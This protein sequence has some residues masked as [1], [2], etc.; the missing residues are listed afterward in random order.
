MRSTL[1]DIAAQ[2]GA[3]ARTLRRAAERGAVHCRRPGPRS[4]ELAPGELT[5][6][7]GHWKLLSVLTRALRTEPN[8]D[9][10]VLYGSAARGTEHARSDID[11]LV[12]FRDD[13]GA[14]TTALARRLEDRV[15]VPV[16]VASLS[17]V[18]R[19]SPLLLLQ[20][21]DEGRVLVDRGD[22][23][24]ALRRARETIARAARRQMDRARKQAAE[25]LASLLQEPR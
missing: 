24:E 5:Y 10:V 23:W 3:D 17:R 19:K 11:I 4:L 7:Q 13:A 16:D 9:L 21:I 14:S 6:L 2:L 8:V 20:A 25:S 22:T 1:P 15:G 18:R 12:D